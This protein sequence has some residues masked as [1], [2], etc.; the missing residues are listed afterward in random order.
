MVVDVIPV[1]LD[2]ALRL[3]ATVFVAKRKTISDVGHTQFAECRFTC[4]GLVDVFLDQLQVT[5]GLPSVGLLC[6]DHRDQTQRN[7]IL[8]HPAVL[9]SLIAPEPR[10]AVRPF[11]LPK[12]AT[13]LVSH[14]IVSYG[15]QGLRG[16]YYLGRG[17]VG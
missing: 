2:S 7:E 12:P 5:D 3:T 8:H 11:A 9:V 16:L 10:H 4:S 14:W 13:N 17:F 1:R 6:P 15:S